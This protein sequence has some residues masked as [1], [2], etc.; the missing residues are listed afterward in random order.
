MS[1]MPPFA[2]IELP[3]YS[4][5]SITFISNGQLCIYKIIIHPFNFFGKVHIL[6][7]VGYNKLL[8]CTLWVW[9]D[10][11]P[12]IINILFF[13]FSLICKLWFD[14]LIHRQKFKIIVSF[15]PEIFYCRIKIWFRNLTYLSQKS[16]TIIK[17]RSKKSLVFVLLCK[18]PVGSF[19]EH[20]W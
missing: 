16:K 7:K 12:P 8:L 19:Q 3:V 14:L 5:S 20:R 10:L 6:Q 9:D 1:S 11:H 2:F 15:N 17:L 13:S 18:K 4:L